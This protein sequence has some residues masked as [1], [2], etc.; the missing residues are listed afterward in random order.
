MKINSEDYLFTNARGN[1]AT[2]YPASNF[3]KNIAE[4]CGISRNITPLT[5]HCSYLADT[6]KNGADIEELKEI[7]G[8]DDKFY[9]SLIKT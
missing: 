1:K 9:S 4:K 2:F 6:I 5:L 8:H 3:L 7:Y